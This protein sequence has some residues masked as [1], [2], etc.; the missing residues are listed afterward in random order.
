MTQL[1]HGRFTNFLEQVDR[2]RDWGWDI[3]DLAFAEAKKSVPAWPEEE[4]GAVVLVPYLADMGTEHGV[5]KTGLERTFHELWVRAKAGQGGRSWCYEGYKNNGSNGLRL[6]EGIKHEIGLRWEVID[7]GCQ[8]NKSPQD[9]RSSSSSPHA[10]ILAAAALHPEWIRSMDGRDVP[11]VWIPGYEV[12]VVGEWPPWA[13]TPRLR[14]NEE[15]AIELGCCKS[16]EHDQKWAVP[17][18]IR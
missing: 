16:N 13:D 9:V 1:V 6:L 11:Y 18:F 12:N 10:G 15:F 2:V 3:P 7:F 17:A 14:R 8:R 4:L 5:T